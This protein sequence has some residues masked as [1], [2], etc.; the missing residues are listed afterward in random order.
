MNRRLGV[1]LAYLLLLGATFGAV[2]VLGIFTAAVIFN[3]ENYL[4]TA[5]LD[6]YNEGVLMAEIF[7][8]FTYWGYLTLGA[9]VAFELYEYKQFW[10]DRIAMI[11]AFFVSATLLLFNAVY[12]P[13][14]LE[15]QL[16]GP[17]AT[18]SE[19]FDNIHV[20]SE[21]DF[22]ILAVALAVLFCRRIML[23]RTIKK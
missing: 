4:Q 16:E 3:S 10:R 6:H 5:L 11:S 1:E 22:K 23:L 12:T 19:A 7:R 8:R 15:M 14:I 20:A 17:E 2:M 18:M 13:R 9:V 21:I